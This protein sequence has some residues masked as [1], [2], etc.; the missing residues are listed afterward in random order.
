MEICNNKKNSLKLEPFIS[1]FGTA[2]KL[3]KFIDYIY[4]MIMI[5]SISFAVSNGI[6]PKSKL[7]VSSCI[8]YLC[9][10]YKF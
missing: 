8:N 4:Y 2:A 9:Q 3:C 7:S 10:I 1:V 6:S 5:I